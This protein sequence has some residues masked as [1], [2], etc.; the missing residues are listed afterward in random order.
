MTDIEALLED[1]L[2]DSVS[3]SSSGCSESVSMSSIDLDA[4]DLACGASST[5]D[6]KVKQQK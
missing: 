3:V 2:S 5:V 4:D 6:L 1:D